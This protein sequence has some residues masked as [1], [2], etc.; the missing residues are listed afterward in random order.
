MNNVLTEREL[1]ALVAKRTA[2]RNSLIAML[3]HLGYGNSISASDL[4]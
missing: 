1:L 4:D 2:Q 3:V